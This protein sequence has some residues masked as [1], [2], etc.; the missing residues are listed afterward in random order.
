MGMILFIIVSKVMF[1]FT[2]FWAYFTSSLA[3]VFNIGG[4]WPLSGIEAISPPGLPLL[5]TPVLFYY[6]LGLVLRGLIMQLSQVLKRRP[7][8]V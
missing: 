5:N 4:V 7:C 1:F 8:L 2:F 6:L 3:P